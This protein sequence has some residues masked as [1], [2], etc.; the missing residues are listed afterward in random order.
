MD[1]PRLSGCTAMLITSMR[2]NDSLENITPSLGIAINIVSVSIAKLIN[3]RFK[4]SLDYSPNPPKTGNK[5]S[6]FKHNKANQ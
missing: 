5:W 4:H 3:T 2:V 1:L 6:Y